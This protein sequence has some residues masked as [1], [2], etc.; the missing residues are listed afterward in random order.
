MWTL[1]SSRKI[2]E[3]HGE[4][5]I[6]NDLYNGVHRNIKDYLLF[7]VILFTEKHGMLRKYLNQKEYWEQIDAI[8]GDRWLVI[9][10]K[11]SGTEPVLKREEISSSAKVAYKVEPIGP[12]HPSQNRKLAE[13]LGIS[14]DELPCIVII[15][16]INDYEIRT[17]A[18]PVKAI[19][20]AEINNRIFNICRI[21]SNVLKGITEENF[22]NKEEIFQ[23]VHSQ[24]SDY[25]LSLELKNFIRKVPIIKLIKMVLSGS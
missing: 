8:S 11:E 16:P 12:Y 17:F 14:N 4:I 22:G 6:V 7:G 3:K 24:I 13:E 15:Q 23:L 2:L 10:S 5:Q 9:I 1:N 18:I 20:E 25:G 21:I 19:N